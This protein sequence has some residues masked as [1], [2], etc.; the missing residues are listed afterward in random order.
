MNCQKPNCKAPALKNDNFCYFHSETTK[1]Q[2][3]NSARKGGSRKHKNAADMKIETVADV[4]AII[5]ECINELRRAN[6]KV[7]ARTR[8]IG[9]LASIMVDAIEKTDIEARIAELEQKFEDE[10]VT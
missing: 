6:V 9:Y 10:N 5:A 8:A 2:R 4:K 7:V 3:A 1:E